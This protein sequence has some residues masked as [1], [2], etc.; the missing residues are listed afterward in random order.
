[1]DIDIDREREKIERERERGKQKP[2]LEASCTGTVISGAMCLGLGSLARTPSDLIRLHLR[3]L[4][5]LAPSRIPRSTTA[6]KCLME[7]FW[8][9]P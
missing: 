7:F 1:M 4:W 8:G 2:S 5:P 9:A 6:A 3:S